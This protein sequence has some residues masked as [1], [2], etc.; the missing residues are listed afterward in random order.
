MKNS[1]SA[2]SA[3]KPSSAKD[4]EG[5]KK[6]RK[7]SD[8]REIERRGVQI[9]DGEGQ[10]KHPYKKRWEV[11]SQSAAGKWYEVALAEN[12][13]HCG[14][15]YHE[16]GGGRRCKH[17]AAVE[18][19]LLRE[20]HAVTSGE[21]LVIEPAEPACRK[22]GSGEYSRD[23]IR[24]CPKRR[25][26]VQRFRCK[27]C[28]RRFSDNLGF[29]G[30]HFA[31]AIITLALTIFAF[32]ISPDGISQILRQAGTTVHPVTVQRWVD[33]YVDLVEAYAN[34]LAPP[35]LGL[36][37]SSDEKNKDIRGQERW[38][39]TVMDSITRFILSYNVATLKFGYNAVPLLETAKKRAGF[40]PRIFVTDGL[41]SF[42]IAFQKVF[43]TLKNAAVHISEIHLKGG[44]CNNN[45][46]E[47]LNGELGDRFKVSRGLKRDD[48]PLIRMAIPHHNFIRSH[49]GLG[50]KA[51]AEAAGIIIRGQ[52]KWLTLIQNAALAAA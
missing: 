32:G 15:K 35:R 10:I 2:D 27:I 7:G 47:R 1:K 26:A 41:P 49:R 6:R 25:D 44:R 43:W 46:H 23:A 38:V 3:S 40:V 21:Q 24:W 48:A 50:G 33:R 5:V 11:A 22:C 39:F 8:P 45:G 14:C 42:G 19:I 16:E 9:A 29:E 51:P 31:P 30:R 17:I 28:G 18:I 52:N 36:K 37:W 34:T 13:F 20:A 4:K 12:G